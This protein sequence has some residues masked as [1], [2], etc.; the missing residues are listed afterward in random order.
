ML[1]CLSVETFKISK[2][3][4]ALLRIFLGPAANNNMNLK[5]PKSETIINP[6]AQLFSFLEG[7]RT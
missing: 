3:V 1:C 6:P 4:M 2:Q 7:T 5:A